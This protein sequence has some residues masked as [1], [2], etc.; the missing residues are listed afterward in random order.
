MSKTE[1][2]WFIVTQLPW[3]LGDWIFGIVLLALVM[4][5]LYCRWTSQ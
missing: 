1:Q 2:L 3:V 5:A 4:V